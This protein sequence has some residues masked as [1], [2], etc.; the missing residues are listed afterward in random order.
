V[1]QRY[2]FCHTWT[3]V[4]LINESWVAKFL[5]GGE[6]HSKPS[7]Q[8]QEIRKKDVTLRITVSH[9]ALSKV[10]LPIHTNSTQHCTFE[11]IVDK[12]NDIVL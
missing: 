5:K 6:M 8:C 1:G 2:S 12:N 4:R 10:A 11:A 3:Q 7:W 9:R